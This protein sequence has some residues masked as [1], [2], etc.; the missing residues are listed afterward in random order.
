MASGRLLLPQWMPALDSDGAPIPNAKVYFYLNLTDTLAPVFSDQA[1]TTP[2]QNPV[3][4]NASGRFPAVWANDA[5]LYSASVEAPYGPAGVPFT[6]DNLSASMAADILVAGAA[7]AAADEAQ[8]ALDDINAAIQA[9]QDADGVAALAGAIA[10]AAAATAVVATKQDKTFVSA[11]SINRGVDNKLTQDFHFFDIVTSPT[12]QAAIRAGTSVADWSDAM[13]EALAR[14]QLANQ[15][16]PGKVMTL[17]Y[18]EIRL[19]RPILKPYG[20]GLIGYG[21]EYTRIVSTTGTGH[22]VVVPEFDR[23]A[24]VGD[25]SIE[26]NVTS[27]A[28]TYGLY[29]SHGT[30]GMIIRRIGVRR[31]AN[32]IFAGSTDYGTIIQP[33]I[34]DCYNDG[35]VQ[36]DTKSSSDPDVPGN[37]DPAV[38]WQ[39]EKPLVRWCQGVAYK[40]T[41]NPS[42]RG[43][44]A[45][46]WRNPG[47]FENGQTMLIAGS[48]PTLSV[49][50]VRVNDGFVGSD[51]LGCDVEAFGKNNEFSFDAIERMGMDSYGPRF[52]PD[53]T[54][55]TRSTPGGA[56]YGRGFRLGTNN[57]QTKLRAT[58]DDTAGYGVIVACDAI[59]DVSV[60]NPGIS[61]DANVGVI[62]FAGTL[63]GQVV[64]EAVTSAVQFTTDESHILTVSGGPAS[65]VATPT[66]SILT[67]GGFRDALKVGGVSLI[68]GQSTGFVAMTGTARKATFATYG[69]GTA[70]A[71]YTQAQIQGIM[72]ALV[73]VSE[74]VKAHDD[75]LIGKKI[76]ST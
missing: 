21:R 13:D 74:R 75:A 24:I 73:A 38:Q 42:G 28:G 31:F 57:Q 35:W 32:G 65:G 12:D 44:I 46:E 9:A 7:E 54:S 14:L 53:G 25:F 63:A 43:H 34:D 51:N 20:A 45:G 67:P 2:L 27:S 39:L 37:Y 60:R 66:S 3:E 17:H 59:L 19:S 41:A 47:T 70:G 48:S 72:D 30:S 5:V 76:P 52:N 23:G 69:G 58:I 10:G 16:D 62:Q 36:L 49:N 22:G 56:G 15:D 33:E 71:A 55:R 61:T 26:R 18:G 8:Q 64:A 50:D 40:A 11:P 6:Y 68:D 29:L 1:L 4:A